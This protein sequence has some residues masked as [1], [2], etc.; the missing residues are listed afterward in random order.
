M[1]GPP[2]RCPLR[3]MTLEKL[4]AFINLMRPLGLA[5]VSR[6]GAVAIARGTRSLSV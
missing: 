4:D 3:P 5:E 6:T 2:Q 1:A